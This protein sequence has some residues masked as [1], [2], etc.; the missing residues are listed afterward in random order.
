V[1]R[2]YEAF[3]TYA[4]RA[5]LFFTLG[6]WGLLA[7]GIGGRPAWLLIVGALAGSAT[8]VWWELA[9]GWREGPGLLGRCAISLA[10][11]IGVVVIVLHCT[12]VLST[13]S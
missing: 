5:G 7:N 6:A 8:Y 4:G 2:R 13:F 11:L 10:C 3:A 1:T 12:R 9:H